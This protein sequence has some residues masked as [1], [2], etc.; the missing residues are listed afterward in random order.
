[1]VTSTA[2][3][4]YVGSG[5]PDVLLRVPRAARSSLTYAKRP[6]HPLGAMGLAITGNP[7]DE[8]HF[9]AMGVAC[10]TQRSQGGARRA[11]D[12]SE[13]GYAAPM[14][15]PATDRFENQAPQLKQHSIEQTPE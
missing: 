1:M 14:A 4:V 12:M 13:V 11:G 6:G 15:S 9:A 8:T 7:L 5:S 10:P 2:C 3:F